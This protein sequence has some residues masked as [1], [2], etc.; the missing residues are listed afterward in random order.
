MKIKNNILV[1]SFIAIFVACQ[2]SSEYD[3]VMLKIFVQ[4]NTQLAEQNYDEAIELY[5]KGIK[6]DSSFADIFN[7]R[8][9]AYFHLKAYEE[10]IEDYNKA[11]ILK[12]TYTD[13]FYNRS[14]AFFAI[15]NIQHCIQ[16]LDRVA[17]K[18]EDSSYVFFNRARA[19]MQLKDFDN[20][21][22]DLN[23]VVLLAPNN[24][25]A[26]G[27]RGYIELQLKNFTAAEKDL[28]KAIELDAKKALAYT[29][30]GVLEIYRKNYTKALN[31]LE[32]SME[33]ND[34]EIYTR[35]YK[36]YTLLMLG[37]KDEARKDI[38]FVLSQKEDA[39]AYL[40]K[41]L[42]YIQSNEKEKGLEYFGKSQQLDST[43]D[44][45]HAYS[46]FEK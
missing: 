9:I 36:A 27:S 13:A 10:A 15:K 3:R 1:L 30:L 2:N 41:G 12:P 17:E 25:D 26:Y 22:Q 14:N 32:K 28:Q 20:S 7:N 31:Y 16:D 39:Q 38:E 44:I 37:K 42:Y 19:Y 18:Y 4:G 45:P 5:T 43:L 46:H 33:I 40:N 35:N 11:I 29:N 24:A 21:L 34:T 8:G 23:K 6:R